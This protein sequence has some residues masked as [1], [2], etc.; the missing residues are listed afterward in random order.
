MTLHFPDVCKGVL[1]AEL[2]DSL[3]VGE[4]GGDQVV[5]AVVSLYVC[6]NVLSII[7]QCQCGSF[8][9]SLTLE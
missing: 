9:S 3:V 5:A 6:A 2:V 1:V 8:V 4:A 7:F